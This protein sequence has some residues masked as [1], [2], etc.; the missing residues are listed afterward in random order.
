M[1]RRKDVAA[2]PIVQTYELRAIVSHVKQYREDT[3]ADG[4]VV[5]HVRPFGVTGA[6]DR[7][8]WYII[9]DFCIEEQDEREVFNFRNDW[10]TVRSDCA[11]LFLCAQ[12]ERIGSL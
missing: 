9:N 10:R 1:Q 12:R 2:A 3:L 11:C 4:H 5:T 8:S 6:A 7:S